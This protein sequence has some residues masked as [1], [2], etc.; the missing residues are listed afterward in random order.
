M[1]LDQEKEA[2][3]IEVTLPDGRKIQSIDY[4]WD[5]NSFIV[6]DKKTG[7]RLIFESAHIIDRKFN[8]ENNANIEVEQVKY[9]M[10]KI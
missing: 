8:F 3:E 1:N 2:E 6:I 10:E 4:S 9:S 7:A 5:G